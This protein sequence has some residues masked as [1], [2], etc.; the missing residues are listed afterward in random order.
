MSFASESTSSHRTDRRAR[1]GFGDEGSAVAGIGPW[2]LAWRRLRRNKVAM[3]FGGLFVLLVVLCLL[4]PVYSHDIA[5]IG[6]NGEN[7]TGTVNV[8]RQEGE[9]R[10]S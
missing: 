2:R 5:H 10:L 7:V 8:G 4:A 3:F 1:R 6:P 9:H